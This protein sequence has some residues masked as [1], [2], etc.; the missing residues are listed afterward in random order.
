MTRRTLQQNA[1]LWSHLTDLANQVPWHVDGK[2]QHISP[3]DWKDIC[4]AGLRKEQRIAAGIESGFVVLGARTSKMTIGQ[5][6]TLIDFV[7]YVGDAR[8]VK[9][10]IDTTLAPEPAP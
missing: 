9:W 6:Q 5:M 7:Q 10:T 2:L 3:S 4:T 8:Q 1:L